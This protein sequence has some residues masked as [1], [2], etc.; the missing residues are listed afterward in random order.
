MPAA[1]PWLSTAA[2]AGADVPAARIKSITQ[3]I[4]ENKDALAKGQPLFRQMETDRL[5]NNFGVPYHPGSVAYYK[6]KGI[7]E[8]K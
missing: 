2:I 5:F 4:A 3:I 1:G 7:A 6:E 8:T